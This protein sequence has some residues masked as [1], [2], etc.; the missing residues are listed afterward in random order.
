MNF[1]QPKKNKVKIKKSN[2]GVYMVTNNR[3]K[4]S[5]KTS[6]G[7]SN[8]KRLGL[9][10]V[11]ALLLFV[12]SFLIDNARY[13]FGLRGDK[14]AEIFL[15]EEYRW[16]ERLDLQTFFDIWQPAYEKDSALD[17]YEGFLDQGQGRY[18]NVPSLREGEEVL[19]GE[20][21]NR[22]FLLHYFYHYVFAKQIPEKS[23][24]RV[25][26][27]VRQ[28]SRLLQEAN[29]E[30]IIDLDSSFYNS[31]DKDYGLRLEMLKEAKL[32]LDR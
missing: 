29:R 25:E 28:E 23:L 19:Y 1:D 13:L 32:G 6:K 18:D 14:E 5:E 2:G 27:V 8:K 17:I 21:L 12:V 22:A 30:G 20:D 7:I 15:S 31:T 10:L 16:Q 4:L 11:L 26:E 9:L 3:V 24:A